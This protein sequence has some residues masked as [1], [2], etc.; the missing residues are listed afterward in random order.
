MSV[1]R[2]LRCTNCH[3]TVMVRDEEIPYYHDMLAWFRVYAPECERQ[4]KEM[5]KAH[6]ID[7]NDMVVKILRRRLNPNEADRLNG[8]E[9]ER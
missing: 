2:H 7:V 9:G 4:A 5:A 1:M 3:K 8:M 6:G